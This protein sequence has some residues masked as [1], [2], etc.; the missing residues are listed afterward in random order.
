[1]EKRILLVGDH[2]SQSPSVQ[3][4]NTYP[5]SCSS[6]IK[7]SPIY[8]ITNTELPEEHFSN[9]YVLFLYVPNLF[10]YLGKILLLPDEITNKLWITNGLANLLV[11]TENKEQALSF[12]NDI[13]IHNHISAFEIWEVENNLIRNTDFEVFTDLKAV[14]FDFVDI[15]ENRYEISHEHQFLVDEYYSAMATCIERCRLYTPKASGYYKK[16]L[17]KGLKIISRISEISSID[18]KSDTDEDKLAGY[19]SDLVELNSVLSYSS[20]QG[21]AGIPPI[22]QNSAVIQSYSLLGIGI[23][24]QGFLAIYIHVNKV[25]SKYAI[26]SILINQH[27]EDSGFDISNLPRRNYLNKKIGV[28]AKESLDHLV[29]FSGRLGFR[30]S[31]NSISAPLFSLIKGAVNNWNL[32]TFSHEY[33]HAHV[34]AL[35][36]KIFSPNWL[37][38][39]KDTDDYFDSLVE[40]YNKYLMDPVNNSAEY[41]TLDC[42][43]FSIIE[44]FKYLQFTEEGLY[45]ARTKQA[46]PELPNITKEW[47]RDITRKGDKWNM[48]NEIIVHTLDYHYFYNGRNDIYISVLWESWSTVPQ[49]RRKLHG[50]IMRTMIAMC[51]KVVTGSKEK[52]DDFIQR[53]TIALRDFKEELQKIISEGKGT[54]LIEEA[55]NFVE[56]KENLRDLRA[57]MMPSVNFIDV[58]MTYLHHP[59]IHADLMSDII[60]VDNTYP[61]ETGDFSG[62]KITSPIAFLQDQVHRN[63]TLDTSDDDAENEFLSIWGSLACSSSLENI[64]EEVTN[65]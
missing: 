3:I 10:E 26:E 44:Y 25:F 20:T 30:E 1:M 43:G 40:N 58:V 13:N 18:G 53:F 57:S 27:K 50:Y 42:L 61:F 2:N 16:I 9:G 62:V 65:V 39:I 23:T 56:D 8:K 17:E 32:L 36:S 46:A 28:D 41:S 38:T 64:D 4:V 6:E 7:S 47:L 31:Q 49:V 34:R 21:Y 37:T 55:L 63:L 29:Y 48:L 60:I 59:S 14:P 33:M 12:K 19:M 11:I 15:P 24:Y 51:S 22:L 35:L 54:I 52:N 45:K 5:A